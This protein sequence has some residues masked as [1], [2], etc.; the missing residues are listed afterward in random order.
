MNDWLYKVYNELKNKGSADYYFRK[1][2]G[3]ENELKEQ[4]FNI[5]IH[6]ID[7]KYKVH[8]KELKINSQRKLLMYYENNKIHA[9]L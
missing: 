4:E 8:E 7:T 6:E 9:L 2:T 5:S 3:L 1:K